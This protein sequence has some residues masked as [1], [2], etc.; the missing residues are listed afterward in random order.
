MVPQ[1]NSNT[2]ILVV[3]SLQPNQNSMMDYG[4]NAVS[5]SSVVFGS[6]LIDKNSSTPYSDATQV[7]TCISNLNKLLK[8][9]H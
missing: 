6:Q 7:S 8:F 5:N 9:I 3:D 2:H 1:L 4:N